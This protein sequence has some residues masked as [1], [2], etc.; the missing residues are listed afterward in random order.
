[1]KLPS[2]V[3]AVILGVTLVIVAFPASEGN[4]THHAVTAVQTEAAGIT[5]AIWALGN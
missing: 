4:V 2:T 1:M 5:P 3:K